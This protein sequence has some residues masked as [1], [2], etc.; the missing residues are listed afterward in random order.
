MVLALSCVRPLLLSDSFCRRTSFV[1]GLILLS[2][3]FCYQ[4]LFVVELL[5]LP[6]SVCCGRLGSHCC[7]DDLLVIGFQGSDSLGDDALG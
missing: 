6:D 2:D 1:V 5:F 7:L 3:P 4:T